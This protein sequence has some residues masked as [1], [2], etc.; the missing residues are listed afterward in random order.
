MPQMQSSTGLARRAAIVVICRRFCQHLSPKHFPPKHFPARRPRAGDGDCH[1][2]DSVLVHRIFTGGSPLGN[3]CGDGRGKS[4]PARNGPS[5][6]RAPVRAA[7]HSNPLRRTHGSDTLV[8]VGRGRRCGGGLHAGWSACARR[9]GPPPRSGARRRGGNSDQASGRDLPG[10]R[11]LRS[12]LRHL[13]LRC[14]YVRPAVPRA[15]RRPRQRSGG[16]A[17]LGWP[18]NASDQQS[19][20]GRKRQSGQSAPAGPLEHQRRFALRPGPQLQRRA[21]GVRRRADGQVHH[22]RRNVVGQEWHRSAVQRFRRHELLRRQHRDRHV[23]L[24]QALRDE[25]QLLRDDIR[26]VDAGSDQPDL[27]QHGWR[28]RDDQRRRHRR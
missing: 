23:E 22:H 2:S 19:K 25:R 26:P 16:H 5:R 12:L 1:P 28:R 6:T 15:A 21:E 4:V 18:R 24:R 3:A 11:L 13:S 17:R 14:E 27:G 20:Q 7:R 10:E 9:A 8:E